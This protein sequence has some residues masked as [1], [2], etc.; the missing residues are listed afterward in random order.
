MT[1]LLLEMLEKRNAAMAAGRTALR[2][3]QVVAFEAAYDRVIREGWRENPR[4]AG[5][6][7]RSKAA[8]LLRRL[9]EHRG[10]ALRFLHDFAVPFTNNEIE[11]DLR[12]TK[13]HE[14]ISGGW[15]S[16]EGARAFLAVRSYLATARKQGTSMLDVL[17]AAFEG[18]PWMPAAAGP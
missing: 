1:N 3:E 10:E 16:M 6:R 18:Q 15:R 2:P 13:L 7:Q 14:K 8:N 11:G 12:M 9:D 17:T 5:K 4:R